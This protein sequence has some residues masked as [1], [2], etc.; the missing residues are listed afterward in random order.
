M[1][2]IIYKTWHNRIL[3]KDFKYKIFIK[4][5]FKISKRKSKIFKKIFDENLNFEKKNDE[6]KIIELKAMKYIFRAKNLFYRVICDETH[7]LR[8]FKI[9]TNLIIFKLR[10][11]VRYL[12][13]AIFMINKSTNLYEILM[14]IFMNEWI[15][16]IQKAIVDFDENEDIVMKNV[17][18]TLILKNFETIIENF[19]HIN[20]DFID[21]FIHFLELFVFWKFNYLFKSKQ[22]NVFIASKILL[23]IFCQI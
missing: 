12:L 8:F 3:N 6:K 10:K 4:S 20:F 11:I 15:I 13:N 19:D 22:M 23:F 18:K 17:K 16:Y 7:K 21:E 2:L 9:K 5:K 1:F 14:Q